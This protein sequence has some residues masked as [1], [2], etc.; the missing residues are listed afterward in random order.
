MSKAQGYI[1]ISLIL[2][3]VFIHM[4]SFIN[5]LSTKMQIGNFIKENESA[6]ESIEDKLNKENV[7]NLSARETMRQ[8][9]IA[10]KMVLEHIKLIMTQNNR[11][12]KLISDR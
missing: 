7:G 8:I 2:I 1:I 11:L 3:I 10:N 6:I 5:G 12:L 4:Y 9:L